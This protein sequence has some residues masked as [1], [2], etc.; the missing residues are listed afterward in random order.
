M[1]ILP[2]NITPRALEEIQRIMN[3]KKIPADYLLRVGVKGGGCGGAAFF[4]AFDKPKSTD[5]QY[6]TAE[7]FSFLMHKGHLMYLLD[8]TLD[9]EERR[10]E[11]GFIFRKPEKSTSL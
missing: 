9:Y 2:I 11:Q 8:V 6:A 5:R 7:G 10:T 4:L 1:E 3:Y